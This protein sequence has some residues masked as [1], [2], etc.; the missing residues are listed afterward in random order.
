MSPTTTDARRL[1]IAN[2]L[3]L[4]SILA[5]ALLIGLVVGKAV[6]KDAIWHEIFI[7]AL[8][9]LLFVTIIATSWATILEHRTRH[10][11]DTAEELA[12]M[13]D[14]ARELRR[15]A[16]DRGNLVAALREAGSIALVSISRDDLNAL[17][18]GRKTTIGVNRIVR[19]STSIVFFYCPAPTSGILGAAL[20]DRSRSRIARTR[21]VLTVAAGRP[22]TTF[23]RPIPI[24]AIDLATAPA[25]IRYL[26]PEQAADLLSATETTA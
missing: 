12:A 21:A 10:V 11:A 17:A 25:P 6:P 26:T 20:I 18:T 1:D 14:T 23:D 3:A 2:G 24:S 4:G 9:P 5:T 19:P 7:N 13:A 16:L 8:I 22:A 15:R